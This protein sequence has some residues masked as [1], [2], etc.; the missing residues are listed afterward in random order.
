MFTRVH[1]NLNS[2]AAIFKFC[3][4]DSETKVNFCKTFQL[5]SMTANVSIQVKQSV[6]RVFGLPAFR[7]HRERPSQKTAALALSM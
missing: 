2:F 5:S 6:I 1:A 4:C 3:M 7:P